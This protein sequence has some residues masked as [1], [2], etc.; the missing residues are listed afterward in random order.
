MVDVMNTSLTFRSALL[1]LIASLAAAF[2]LTACSGQN[3]D[4][5]ATFNDADV[6]FAT[7]M[8][9]HH[10]Q[11]IVMSRW[12]ER[13][14]ADPQVKA[15]ADRIS[16]AQGPE[17]KT[18][19]AWLKAWDQPVPDAYDPEHGGH[20]MDGMDKGSDG[21][22]SADDMETLDKAKGKAFDREF[23]RQMIEHHKVAVAMAKDELTSGESRDA[24]VL[25]TSI[26][27]GQTAEIA[28]MRDLL[29]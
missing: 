16:A 14:A 22:M 25:A 5:E 11:A 6:A 4:T 19:T 13:R 18:M 12:A 15:L 20:S 23:L 1:P 7:G 27:Q 29:E 17:I 9:P 8:I 2:A 26:I 24:K 21:M 28:E 10:Q 3:T